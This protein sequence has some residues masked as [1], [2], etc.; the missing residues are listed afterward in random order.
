MSDAGARLEVQWSQ[1]AGAV[2][3]RYRVT[4]VG[5]GRLVV[6]D[7]VALRDEAGRR[8]PDPASAWVTFL[9]DG[10]VLV[11]KLVPEIPDSIDVM[12]PE[13]PYARLVR[14]GEVLEGRA[15]LRLPLQER[16]PYGLRGA[17][18]GA[19]TAWGQAR[20]GFAALPER[21]DGEP[22]GKEVQLPWGEPAWLMR[23]AWASV[24]QR[25]LVSV[26]QPLEVS[27]LQ[28]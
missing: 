26:R 25:V 8:V 7:R 10:G 27:V 13:M 22:Q 15:V 16:T 6:F 14:A 28:P 1:E 21:W 3:L 17:A 23:H 9:A 20:I 18:P 19:Q 5:A 12:S 4:N 2:L 11:D 24:N